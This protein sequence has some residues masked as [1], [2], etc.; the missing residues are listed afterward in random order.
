MKTKRKPR[1]LFMSANLCAPVKDDITVYI[2]RRLTIQSPNEYYPILD[3]HEKENLLVGLHSDFKI[4]TRISS[5]RLNPAKSLLDKCQEG[6]KQ[7]VKG[8]FANPKI[9][10]FW[11]K[12]YLLF[13]KFDL[14]IRLDENS[15]EIILP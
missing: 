11:S 8:I 14:G 4:L 1:N 2:Q 9:D 6:N 5:V 7:T 3:L 10:A 12:R 15:C 13:E